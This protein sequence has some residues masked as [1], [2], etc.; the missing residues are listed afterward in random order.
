MVQQPTQ[1]VLP[2]LFSLCP[3]PWSG[4]NP[5]YSPSNRQ[6]TEWVLNSGV[7]ADD[8]GIRAR[9]DATMPEMIGAYTFPYADGDNLRIVNDFI[10]ILFVWDEMTDVQDENGASETRNAVVRALTGQSGDGSPLDRITRDFMSRVPFPSDA[11]RKRFISHCIEYM[12]ATIEEASLRE[13]GGV[14]SIE[15]YLT[16]RRN[17]GA[18]RPCFDLIEV[19]LGITLP[20]EVLEDP[21]FV[22]AWDAAND[23]VTWSNACLLSFSFTYHRESDIYSFALEYARGIEGYNVINIIMQGNSDKFLNI[24]EAMDRVAIY[25]KQFGET[26]F[27]CTEGLLRT[28]S[29][30]SS[31]GSEKIDEAVRAYMFGLEQW[32]YG[33]LS[34]SFDTKRYFGG[35]NEEVKRTG[36]VK[37]LQHNSVA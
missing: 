35:L 8:A 23:M 29:S 15:E 14:L 30:S 34:W 16:F 19:V 36:V 21:N 31:I 26:F 2:D 1:L 4:P 10:M 6:T 11:V 33:N 28:H 20:R 37:L 3:F 9:L 32:V 13:E 17:S 12:D 5:H 18:V 7:F 24:Q 22:R 25:F 27:I